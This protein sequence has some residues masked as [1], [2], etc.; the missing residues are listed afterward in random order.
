M[1]SKNHYGSQF[2]QKGHD[3]VVDLGDLREIVKEAVAAK[4]ESLKES[5]GSAISSLKDNTVSMAR[6]SGERVTRIVSRSPW[7]AMAGAA[8]AGMLAVWLYRRT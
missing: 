2:R 3:L 8:A 6:N 4:F 5:A 7:K 1:S